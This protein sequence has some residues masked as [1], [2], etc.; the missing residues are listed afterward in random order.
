[1]PTP[2]QLAR[3]KI[4]AQ[5]EKAGWLVRDRSTFNRMEGTGVA[6]REWPTP[7]GPCDYM[8]FVGGKAVGVVEAKPA[9]VTLSGVGEQSRGYLQVE[10]GKLATWANPLLCHYESTGEETKFCWMRDPKP[11]SRPVFSFHRPE[12]LLE[13]AQDPSSL[14]QRLL[15]MPTLD[16]AGLRDCQIEAVQGLERSLA[17]DQ[18]RSLL[19]MATGSGKTFTACTFSNRLLRYAGAKRILFLVD[20]NNLG[21]Q[22]LNEFQQYKPAG[23]PHRFAESYIVD[24]LQRNRI[25]PDAK[26]VI[27]TIQ[28]LYS[29]LR[30]EE[31]LAADE[32]KSAF[33]GYFGDDAAIRPLEYNPNLP[34]EMFDF[35]VTDECHR[36]IYG[37]WRQVLEY[38]DAKIIGLTATPSK[39][40]LGFFNKNLVAEYPYER[41]VVDG[42]NVGYEVYRIRTEFL[43]QGGKV[44]AG[45]TVPIR[46]KRTRAVR[47]EELE[48]DIVFQPTE[49]DRKV[50]APD[51]IRTVL[52]AYQDNLFTDLFPGRT[53]KWVPK[54]LIFAKDDAHAENIVNIAREVFGEGNAFAKKITY[55]T[56]E[57]PQALIK[58]FRT[59]PFPRIAVTVDMI[60]TGT[61]IRPLEVLIFMRDVRSAGYFEQMKGRGVRSVTDTE[62]QQVT[63][64]ATTKTRFVLIDAVGVTETLKEVSQPLEMM[65]S[66]SFEQIMEGMAAGGMKTEKVVSSLAGRLAVLAKR[67]KE[68][69]HARIEEATGGVGLK[70]ISGGLLDAL[71]P[72]KVEAEATA[73]YGPNP[74]AEQYKQAQEDMIDRAFMPLNNPAVRQLI[75]DI[76]TRSE[77]VITDQAD[78]FLGASFDLN[79]AQSTITS[80]TE[81]LAKHKDEITALQILY[82]LPYGKQRLSYQQIK[83]LAEKLT[84]PPYHLTTATVWQAYKRLERSR[85]RGAPVDNQLTEIIS[86][87]R[88]AIGLERGEDVQLESINAWV[89][90]RYNLWLGRMVKAGKEFTPEQRR[91]LDTIRDHVANNGEV[92][93][94]DLQHMPSFV[95]Q[96]GFIAAQR[97]FTDPPLVKL[98]DELTEA[99]VA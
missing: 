1:M 17:D 68:A 29:M 91:W 85:V 53:G 61:D 34:I 37:L 7:V 44:D 63:P 74:T 82:N 27:T 56:S 97:L 2:E 10:E 43:Q 5:L 80:F 81:F 99:L 21:R 12:T 49:L 55:N 26:V 45:Y 69:D 16:T 13:M 9:G 93:P 23:S 77:I 52:T 4:D 98:L 19:Q 3:Q 48:E 35:V 86:L 50:E 78:T 65:R 24:H 36:S 39:H 62:L 67:L 20:R 42:V 76:K 89:Q 32:E 73:T 28:R 18:P 25:A 31:D 15:A 72:E 90:A 30:G 84:D 71:E 54:T 92:M 64:D 75:L 58:E 51:T 88:F 60:A 41:S 46:D 95:A 11:R 6:V 14:R 79:H 57:D 22:T 47:Y 59:S 83:D 87:V 8:L 70:Q 94:D 96:G 38:F 40:T 33:E 66:A